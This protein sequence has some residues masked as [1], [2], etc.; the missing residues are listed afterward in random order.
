MHALDWLKYT[1]I[2]ANAREVPR[3]MSSLSTF[4]PLVQCR[5]PSSGHHLPYVLS[6]HHTFIA[7][8]FFHRSCG[9]WGHAGEDF[10]SD[11]MLKGL[12]LAAASGQTVLTV[13]VQA[14]RLPSS[15]PPCCNASYQYY[16]HQVEREQIGMSGPVSERSHTTSQM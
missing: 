3:P 12:Q 13:N 9:N 16:H 2:G 5:L 14:K 15:K 6:L 1:A 10:G 8:E 7:H 4:E 11:Q